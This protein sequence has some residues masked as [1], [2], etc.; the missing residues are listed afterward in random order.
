MVCGDPLDETKFK[1]AIQCYQKMHPGPIPFGAVL[2]TVL[3]VRG[4][5]GTQEEEIWNTA[6][7]VLG[8]M[9]YTKKMDGEREIYIL[10][11]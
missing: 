2:E 11:E 6:F 8:N 7:D 1:E 9:G 4:H 3:N 5:I 10:S